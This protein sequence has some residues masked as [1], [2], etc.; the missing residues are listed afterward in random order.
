MFDWLSQNSH[1]VVAG[2][3]YLAGG[4][5]MGFGAIGAGVGEGINAGEAG[6]QS[7]N[8]PAV[9]GELVRTMLVGQAIAETSG[10]FALVVAFVLLFGSP[11]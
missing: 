8:Q 6:D 10:I 1:Q 9:H 7:A 11:T 2:V 3:Q 5:A 4:I